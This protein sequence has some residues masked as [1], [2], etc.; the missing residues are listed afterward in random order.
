MTTPWMDTGC[1][2]GRA[3]VTDPQAEDQVD[4]DFNFCQMHHTNL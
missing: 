4:V 2:W 1:G 3:R